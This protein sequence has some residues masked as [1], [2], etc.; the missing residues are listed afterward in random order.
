MSR[1]P[2]CSFACGLVLLCCSRLPA[3]DEAK[4]AARSIEDIAASAKKSLAVIVFTGRDGKEQGLGT[5]FVVGADGLIATNLHV[6]G[7]ARPVTVQLADGKR[8]DV[9]TIHASDRAADL[10]LLRID[11]KKLTPLPLGDSDRLKPGQAIVALGHPHGLKFSVVSGVLSGRRD[12]DGRSMLQLAIPIEKGNSGGPVLDLQGRVQGI[13][14]MKALVTPN[15]GFAVPVSALKPLLQKPNPIPMAQWLTI[16]AL[17]PSEWKTLFG[18]RWR[19][20]AGRLIAEGMGSGFGGRTLCLWQR[21]LPAEPY[22]VGAKVRLADEAGAAGLVLHADG[23]NKHYGFYPSAG[24]LRL[25]RFEGPDVFSWKVLRE[26]AS[27]HYQPGEWNALKVRIDR[28]RIRCYVN[29]HLVIE[30]DDHGLSGGTVGL[31]MF[32]DTRAEFKHFQV[33]PKLPAARPPAD[34]VARVRKAVDKPAAEPAVKAGMVDA[35]LPDAPASIAVL[36]ERAARLDKEA[37]GLRKLALAVH[38]RR[39][40]GDLTR[41]LQAKEADIDLL[42]AALLIAKLDNEEL[43]VD[44]YRQE[45]DRLARAAAAKLPANAAAATKLAALNRYLFTERGFHGSRVDYY[46]RA[47]SY[48]NEVI[49]DREGLPITLSVL[50]MELARR[51]GLNV[52]GVGL[53]GHFVVKHVPPQGEAQLIDV[54]DGG[55]PLSQEDAAQIVRR[56]RDQPLEP[57]DLAAVSKKAIL[58]RMLHNLWNVAQRERDVPGMLRYVDAILAL[59]PASAEE[60]V[61]RALL[62]MQTGDRLGALEDADW[63]LEHAPEGVDLDRVR[64]LRAFLTRP[65]R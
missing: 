64:E 8:Y 12:I 29:D 20:R 54:Y 53:P 65:E 28:D 58:V 62:R 56:I 40:I 17:D 48:L 11:A 41:L 27:E 44:A 1:R 18:A 57:E 33:A 43:D 6:L 59:A 55:K 21:P 14:T 22:E 13:V 39:V 60:R 24:K 49:D 35:L 2:V 37:A 16:G 9:T 36:R 31:A 10:A 7:E 5:G 23:G 26:L 47:N 19:Q 38:Q 15:L 46:T 61:A 4:P 63:L 51:L 25:T 52:V 32:R 45:V 42:H 50:Y 3:A 34:L 30:S